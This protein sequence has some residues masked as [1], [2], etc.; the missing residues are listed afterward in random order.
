M[1][2]IIH[3]IIVCVST[4]LTSCGDP[5]QKFSVTVVDESGVPMKGIEC[6]AGFNRGKKSGMGLE[7][8]GV[9]AITNSAGKAE[10]KGETSFF[11]STIKAKTD[12]HYESSFGKMWI[13]KRTGNHWE[14]WPVEVKL[15]MKKIGNPHPM[16]VVSRET[17]GRFRYPKDVSGPV[18]FDLLR[19]DWVAPHGKG[20]RADLYLEGVKGGNGG[21]SSI[22]PG[23]V[24][25]TF[26]NPGDGV[27]PAREELGGSLLFGPQ[28]APEDGYLKEWKFPNYR[29]AEGE[30]LNSVPGAYTI[31]FRIRTELDSEGKVRSA[32]YGKLPGGISYTYGPYASIVRMTYYLNEQPNDRR[33]E[34]DMQTN[35]FRDITSGAPHRP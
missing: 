6:T 35:L 31:V 33:M 15:I 13:K 26:P 5:E 29:P 30:D 8:Y 23:H 10:I 34:W 11:D 21:S 1:K 24:Q 18:G 20:E 28:E 4:C 25:L 22:P 2:N 19:R 14:P 3:I 7:P 12:D 9:T 17:D 27:F 32:Y 16:Y